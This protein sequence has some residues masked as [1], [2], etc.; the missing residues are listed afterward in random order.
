MRLHAANI[1]PAHNHT[2]LVVGAVS[3]F[4]LPLAI[5]SASGSVQGQPPQL[6]PQLIEIPA[7]EFEDRIR[8]GLLGQII[9]NLNGLPHEAKYIHEPGSV[10]DF[11]PHLPEGARTDDDTDL[12]WVYVTEIERTRELQLPPERIVRLW[13]RH[14]NDGIW[15]ANRYARD[16]MELGLEPPATGHR[17][18]NPWA[19]FNI[20]GQFLCESFGL[21]APAMPQ[22]AARLATHYTS[23][24]IDGEPA[25]VARLFASM[26]ALAFVESDLQQLLDN[27]LRAVD[28]ECEIAAIVTETRRICAEH[29][30]DWRAARRVFKNRWQRHDGAIRDWN[31]YELNTACTIAALEYG[32]GDFIETLQLACNFGWD[33]DNNAATAAT[34]LGVIR[35]R[36]WMNA[37]GWEIADAYRNTT[38]PGMPNDETITRF[39]DRVIACARLA[40]EQQ[41]GREAMADGRAVLQIIPEMPVS[42]ASAEERHDPSLRVELDGSMNRT[43]LARAAYVA[44]CTGKADELRTRDPRTW[45]SAVDALATFPNVIRN[46]R[47]PQIPTTARLRDAAERAGIS[48]DS[49]KPSELP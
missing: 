2:R 8:G 31:G 12:E 4:M 30:D 36:R 34:I 18:L 15:C 41:G 23:A 7:D 19:E 5:W 29:P 47:D 13:Q 3:A 44:I 27:G 17:L 38:R 37:Q 28:P 45:A 40:I 43:E 16:L 20:S 49:Q 26:I 1:P 11:R 9:G 32:R 24:A 22:T 39:E 10:T 21:M 42:S 35:G 33:C 14:I 48:L 6:T 46:I 25:Q